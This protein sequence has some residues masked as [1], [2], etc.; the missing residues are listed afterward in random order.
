MIAIINIAMAKDVQAA[1]KPRFRGNANMLPRV[2]LHYPKNLEREYQ[3]ITNAYMALLNRTLAE[4]LPTIRRA[5]AQARAGTRHDA[6]D[7]YS[8]LI[9][10][11]NDV[12]MDVFMQIQR[13][14]Q[15]RA[16]N[17]NLERRINTLANSM[18]QL[19]VA[20]WR[21][22]VQTSLGINIIQDYYMGE[23]F[24]N[25]LD[26]W[27]TR[28]IGLI[29]S[30]P[31]N[32]LTEVRNIVQESWQQGLINRDISS[33]IQDAYN[34]NK[35]R[36]QF[37]ARDQMAKLNA[38]LSQAQQQDAG[39]EEY[40]WSTSGDERVRGNPSGLWPHGDHYFLDGKRFKW[41]DPPQVAPGR[42]CHPGEDYNC[43]CVALPVFNLP[44]LSLP[45]EG[46][47]TE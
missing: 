13:D 34:G 43:R 2:T 5:M 22:L 1:V 32:T 36:A 21:Q 35:K 16:R 39:C 6:Y 27:T 29:T 33:K 4:H 9:Y 28:N 47:N 11:M 45:W 12:I 15:R 41:T 24:R 18:R 14:F 23:F 7:E 38:D 25:A 3:R 46:G 44:G 8:E 30:V 10:G 40:I 42:N 37:W 26:V 19:S 31:Q 17:F 20:Q